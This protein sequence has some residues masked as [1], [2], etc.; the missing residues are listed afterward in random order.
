[1]SRLPFELY[2]PIVEHLYRDDLL[3]VLVVSRAFQIEA[4]RLLYDRIVIDASSNDD[5]RR[6]IPRLCSGLLS[7]PRIWPYVREVCILEIKVESTVI[8]SVAGLLEK[9]TNLD[10]LDVRDGFNEWPS[11]GDLFKNCSFQ[12]NRLTCHFQLDKDFVSFLDSQKSLDKFEW[13]PRSVI[14][15]P[16]TFTFCELPPSA[17][18]NLRVYSFLGEGDP[19]MGNILHDRPIGHFRTSNFMPNRPDLLR[20]LKLSR[21]TLK[22]LNLFFHVDA[23]YF[24]L[25]TEAFPRLEYLAIVDLT[26]PTIVSAM[27]A[28][29]LEYYNE[30]ALIELN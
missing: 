14:H 10:V 21:C 12:L 13:V 25:V 22:S 23:T 4:E 3:R 8:S 28:Q 5:K 17:L 1:M 19:T 18:Q 26:I 20:D 15:R 9:S 2:N 16:H 29:I 24:C 27:P 6:N 7:I 30:T 11:C